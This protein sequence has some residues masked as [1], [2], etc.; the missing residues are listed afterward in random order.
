MWFVLIQ[1]QNFIKYIDW[2]F[3][4]KYSLSFQKKINGMNWLLMTIDQNYSTNR[5]EW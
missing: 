2:K 5:T 1:R 3:R 4:S